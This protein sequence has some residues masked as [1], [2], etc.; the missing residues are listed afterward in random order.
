MQPVLHL[1]YLKV[2]LCILLHQCFL[3]CEVLSKQVL[4]IRE[5][6]SQFADF[7][8]SHVAEHL[9]VFQRD[10]VIVVEP[11]LDWLGQLVGVSSQGVVSLGHS[12]GWLLVCPTLSM[13]VGV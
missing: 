7:D 11:D 9:L 8:C 6:I 5:G 12:G 13:E 2:M 1:L 3:L 10:P 4:C